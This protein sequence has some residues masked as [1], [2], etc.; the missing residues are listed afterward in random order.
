M[1]NKRAGKLSGHWMNVN[2]VK[3]DAGGPK[4][5]AGHNLRDMYRESR[6]RSNIDPTR[7]HLNAVLAGPTTSAD[8]AALVQ[9]ILLQVGIIKP[10]KNSP[11]LIEF[12]FTFPPAK[13]LP[14]E[15]W[16]TCLRWAETRL[17]GCPVVSAVVHADESAPHCHALLVPLG[18]RN[19]KPVLAA[20]SLLGKRADIYNMRENFRRTVLVPFGLAPQE[21]DMA[22]V[23]GSSSTFPKEKRRAK[24]DSLSCVGDRLLSIGEGQVFLGNLG[25]WFECH[26]ANDPLFGLTFR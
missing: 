5:A 22:V 26:A 19:G 3:H 18:Q 20:S 2:T 8:V 1:V 4:I 11:R 15:Y 24:P 10:R 25:S 16:H 6:I 13:R 17:H 21:T 23:M 9:Q 12:V 7:S 14:T